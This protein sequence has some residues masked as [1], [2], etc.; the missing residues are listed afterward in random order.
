M[1]GIRPESIE[2]YAAVHDILVRAFGQEEEALLVG[3]LREEGCVIT[4]LVAESHGRVIGH[5]A[6]STLP[7]EHPSGDVIAAAMAPVA[8]H[9]DWQRKGIG[10]ALIQ[11]GL[12]ICVDK[13]VPA[14]IVLGDP[15][16]YPRFGF[17][18]ELGATL[19]HP[20]PRGP[21]FM[22]LEL[23]QGV[24]ASAPGARVRYPRAFRVAG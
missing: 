13:N 19:K 18:A 8:V 16:F 20:F 7:L 24:L 17:S 1:I 2:D 15:L 12:S 5:I 6:F 10:S 14:V 3:A 9:P 22:A 23:T 11:R 21:H 4:A